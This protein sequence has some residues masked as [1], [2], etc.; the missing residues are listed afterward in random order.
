MDSEVGW[1]P[2]L[3][4]NQYLLPVAVA[5]IIMIFIFIYITFSKQGYEVTVIGESNN[6]ARYA[7]I[8]VSK[9]IMRTMSISGAICGLAGFLQV[10]GISHTISKG[11]IG[12]RG[13]TAIIVAWG[14]KLNP[15]IMTVFSLFLVF[16]EKGAAQIAS[17]F[18]FNQYASNVV[19][20][21]ML[22]FILA[23]EFFVNYNLI[24]R[25]REVKKHDN[26]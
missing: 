9:V 21:I 14:S 5:V 22:L 18:N 24:F 3:F 20:G 19:T 15:F 6:T 23:S 7:G 17:D 8:N 10:S 2:P 25:N 16:L 11:I 26:K 13:F 12:G 1:L 4:T